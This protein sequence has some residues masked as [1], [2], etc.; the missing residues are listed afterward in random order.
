[1]GASGGTDGMD[2]MGVGGSPTSKKK[3]KKKKKGERELLDKYGLSNKTED[4]RIFMRDAESR[5]KHLST[6]QTSKLY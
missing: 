1:M 5:K 4:Y 6:M 3:G 2:G